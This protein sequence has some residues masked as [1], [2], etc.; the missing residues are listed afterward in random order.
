MSE[1]TSTTRRVAA[2]AEAL[3]TPRVRW[4]TG[5]H[6]K[7]E[8]DEKKYRRIVDSIVHDEIERQL[9]IDA[10]KEKGPLTVEEL[11]QL[12]S[13]QPE[14][15]MEHIIALRKKGSIGEAGEKEDKYLF[16]LVKN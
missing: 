12:T 14:R 6:I 11:S 10:I 5:T 13:L 8:I 15:V 7:L 16:Q 2:E 1:K 9:I 3:K 4:V